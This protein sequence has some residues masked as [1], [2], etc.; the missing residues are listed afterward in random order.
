MQ[1]FSNIGPGSSVAQT[2]I[3]YGKKHVQIDGET[4]GSSKVSK[5]HKRTSYVVI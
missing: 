3:F 2:N 5:S 4:S 1:Y